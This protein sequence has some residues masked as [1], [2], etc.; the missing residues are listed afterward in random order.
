MPHIELGDEV[1]YYSSVLDQKEPILGWVCRRPG[2]S[3]V[4]I[5]TFSPDQGF[6][7]KPSVRHVDDPGLQEN[8]GWRQWGA[9]RLHPRAELLRKLDTLLPQVVT[10][11]ARGSKKGE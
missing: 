9:Y 5:L 6:I 8:A 11:L 2:V 4:S 3:T 10:L 7:E 1:L